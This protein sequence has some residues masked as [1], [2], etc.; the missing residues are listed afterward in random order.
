MFLGILRPLSNLCPWTESVAPPSFCLLADKRRN[1]D[2]TRIMV[3]FHALAL[4]TWAI[5]LVFVRLKWDDGGDIIKPILQVN[6]LIIIDLSE[7]LFKLL[8]LWTSDFR[9][10]NRPCIRSRCPVVTFRTMHPGTSPSPSPLRKPPALT[11]HR[12]CGCTGSVPPQSE[13]G[14]VCFIHSASLMWEAPSQRGRGSAQDH[15]KSDLM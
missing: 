14:G 15:I 6:S 7:L 4:W 8:S 5:I 1:Q 11:D 2:V 12:I 13:V 3:A 9:L 10:N